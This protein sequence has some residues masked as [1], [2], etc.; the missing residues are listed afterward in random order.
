MARQLPWR[1]STINPLNATIVSEAHKYLE[2]FRQISD[3]S[4]VDKIQR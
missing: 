4:N 3:S 2:G 1:W